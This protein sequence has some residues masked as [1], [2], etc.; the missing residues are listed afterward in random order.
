MRSC[1]VAE[2]NAIR[3]T[4]AMSS[5]DLM[6]SARQPSLAGEI[7]EVEKQEHVTKALQA[8][9]EGHGMKHGIITSPKGPKPQTKGSASV[10][11]TP[12]RTPK[13]VQTPSPVK[14]DDKGE[15]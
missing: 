7:D 4:P 3:G 10:V 13:K 2:Q 6:G 15:A 1:M 11:V 9:V 14:V 5:R 12:Q 8:T